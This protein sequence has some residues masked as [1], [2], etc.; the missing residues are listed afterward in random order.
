MF[1]SSVS[2]QLVPVGSGDMECLAFNFGGGEFLLC[3]TSFRRHFGGL[4]PE[5]TNEMPDWVEKYERLKEYGVKEKAGEVWG[6]GKYILGKGIDSSRGDEQG[7][8]HAC[9]SYVS[10]FCHPELQAKRDVISIRDIRG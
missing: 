1:L 2:R 10:L 5:G 8:G 7:Y 4:Q 9:N 6:D 3:V